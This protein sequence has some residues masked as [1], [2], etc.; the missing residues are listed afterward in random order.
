MNSCDSCPI[1]S[2]IRR[3]SKQESSSGVAD[4]AKTDGLSRRGLRQARASKKSLKGPRFSFLL[5]ISL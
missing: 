1:D 5:N 2:L 4:L 3:G